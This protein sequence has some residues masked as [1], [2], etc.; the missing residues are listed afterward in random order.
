[1]AKIRAMIATGPD[2]W[3]LYAGTRPM[4]MDELAD[5]L[6]HGMTVVRLAAL[7]AE[8]P[9]WI[10]I[11]PTGAIIAPDLAA[12]KQRSQ[13]KRRAAEARWNA[14]RYA[15][16]MQ[17]QSAKTEV[18][19]PRGMQNGCTKAIQKDDAEKPVEAPVFPSPRPQ[20]SL[21]T[22]PPP[23]EPPNQEKAA[24]S[25]VGLP[26]IPPADSLADSTNKN[27]EPGQEAGEEH[28]PAVAGGSID[29]SQ[30]HLAE[31]SALVVPGSATSGQVQEHGPAV[32]GS[33]EEQHSVEA[34]FSDLSWVKE[35]A[36]VR[37]HLFAETDWSSI[38]DQAHLSFPN[39]GRV[40]M[41]VRCLQD[42]MS[43]MMYDQWLDKR[44]DKIKD[45]WHCE[46]IWK[47]WVK[48]WYEIEIKAK[49]NP[50][51]NE[52]D[53]PCGHCGGDRDVKVF[54]SHQDQRLLTFE[55]ARSEYRTIG[56]Y[57]TR[58]MTCPACRSMPDARKKSLWTRN[59]LGPK[60]NP[61][62]IL[63]MKSGRPMEMSP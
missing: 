16:N 27:P 18:T 41:S 47:S 15:A 42:W 60:I 3:C 43:C 5:D 40:A 8:V 23:L 50:Y 17:E 12:C 25:S 39:G 61:L 52:N 53:A 46:R 22:L 11:D 37:F 63:K 26:A 29:Q 33:V 24:A 57:E 56:T 55:E 44:G 58:T 48:K 20:V 51:G 13:V 19:T 9:E 30:E 34:K 54:W 62:D 7:I 36:A 28:G 4:T 45:W 32:G 2:G 38:A 14:E 6:G 35:Q 10:V 31:Q 21:C 1:M 49:R 59:C